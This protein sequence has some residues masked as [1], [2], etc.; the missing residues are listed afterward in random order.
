MILKDGR[1][2][3]ASVTAT[4][5]STGEVAVEDQVGHNQ[6]NC[7]TVGHWYGYDCRSGRCF[8]ASLS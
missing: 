5:R 4:P 3:E 7:G 2:R 1:R 6:E 8:K